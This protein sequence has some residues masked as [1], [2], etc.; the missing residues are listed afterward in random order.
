MSEYSDE[1]SKEQPYAF[2]THIWNLN[3]IFQGWLDQL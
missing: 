1:K 2:F 3:A